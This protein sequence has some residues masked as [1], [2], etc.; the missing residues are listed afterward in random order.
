MAGGSGQRA[1]S[2][3]RNKPA[4][5]QNPNNFLHVLVYIKFIYNIYIIYMMYICETNS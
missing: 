5:A 2:K 3:K 1:K 4:W